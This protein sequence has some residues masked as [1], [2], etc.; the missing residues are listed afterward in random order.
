MADKK[1]MKNKTDIMIDALK[2]FK[3]ASREEEIK[4]H[5]KP[6]NHIKVFKNKKK[7]N[8]KHKHRQNYD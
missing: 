1:I 7:Y 4:L 8:R 6:I 2:A 3:K 5:G